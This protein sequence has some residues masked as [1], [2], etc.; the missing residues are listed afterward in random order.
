MA[1][2]LA[3]AAIC[4][5][6]AKAQAKNVPDGP[7]LA[8][9]M[10]PERVL[11]PV[12]LPVAVAVAAPAV[13]APSDPPAVTPPPRT[14]PRPPQRREEPE[15]PPEAAPAAA[16]GPAEP[17]DLRPTSPALDAAAEREVRDTLARAARDLA[18]V[19]YARLTADARSQYDQS[20]R[21]TQQAEEALRDRNFVFAATL[22]DKA[23]TLA[24]GLTGR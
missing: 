1:A 24:A 18:R 23:A 6:C 22:A 19:D 9:P 21:F 17:R 7:P 5:A 3:A 13:E 20:K 12:E 8:M 2:C 10:P 11:A 16:E 15:R 4:G 14:P